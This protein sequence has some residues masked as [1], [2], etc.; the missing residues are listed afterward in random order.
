MTR[1]AGLNSITNTTKAN[2]HDDGEEQ[3]C[4]RFALSSRLLDSHA[5]LVFLNQTT[6]QI[7]L[8]F[9]KTL[10]GKEIA[11][12]LKNNVVMIGTLHSADP[13][14]NIKLLNVKIVDDSDASKKKYPQLTSL[15]NCFIRGSVVRYIQI[16][17]EHVD[18]EL[19]QD[20]ARKE[21][22]PAQAKAAAKV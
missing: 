8:S 16:P 6:I 17:P 10:V 3:L 12:E 15:Q 9:F 20:A 13:Y 19:L 1:V 2:R 11:V 21:N 7:F 18:I 22:G 4:F 14:L 5:K